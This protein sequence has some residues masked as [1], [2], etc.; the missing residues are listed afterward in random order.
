MTASPT[1]LS[2]RQRRSKKATTTPKPSEEVPL[3]LPDYDSRPT[4][5]TLLD[6]ADERRAQLAGGTPFPKPSSTTVDAKTEGEAADEDDGPLPAL[7]NALL[8]CVSLSMLHLTLD[9]IVLTQYA[10]EVV[11]S[12][13][14]GRLARLTPALLCLL[15]AFHT[16]TAK[17]LW[18]A[19]QVFFLGLAVVAGCYLLYAGNE[20][21]YY[22][23]MR[24]APPLGTL[25]VWSVVEM[26]LGFAVG[27]LAV[28]GGYAW[29]KGYGAF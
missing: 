3:T 29:W 23:V 15:W 18:V 8:Y 4:G 26:D 24:R 16:A 1:P 25:W 27:H 17:R 13:V 2:R 21:G 28:V 22:F 7:A 20:H 11:W 14:F 10:Q 19:R 5:K 9:V 6:L 12:E